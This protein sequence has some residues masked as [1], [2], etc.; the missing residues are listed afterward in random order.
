MYLWWQHVGAVGHLF[1]GP[2]DASPLLFTGG[3]ASSEGG[4]S[5]ICR[6]PGPRP[7]RLGNS[8][9]L[10]G[11][12]PPSC[13][14][15]FDNDSSDNDSICHRLSA[16]DV[17]CSRNIITFNPHSNPVGNGALPLEMREL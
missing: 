14:S 17:H 5:R 12:N 3:C 9:V 4:T 13:G 8:F 10:R 11:Q 1:Q 15:L 16:W 7:Y 6:R 2:E